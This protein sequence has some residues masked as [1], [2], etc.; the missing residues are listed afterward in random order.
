MCSRFAALGRDCSGASDH[1]SGPGCPHGPSGGGRREL[2]RRLA[3]HEKCA[4][5]DFC[6]PQTSNTPALPPFRREDSCQRASLEGESILSL[7]RSG[8]Q[9]DAAQIPRA[10]GERRLAVVGT[11]S[12]RR[13]GRQRSS[14]R[15]PDT[16]TQA[17]PLAA[18]RPC[19]LQHVA[20]QRGPYTHAVVLQQRGSSAA[21][22]RRVSNDASAAPGDGVG[23]DEHAR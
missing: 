21:W 2:F 17:A 20:V 8:S 5:F 16:P 7:P 14:A 13:A 23:V 11:V 10:P 4:G 9:C 22:A 3:A 12:K 1:S 18:G 15:C 19:P 6:N